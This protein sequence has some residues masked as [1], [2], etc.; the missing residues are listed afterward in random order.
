MLLAFLES[1]LEGRTPAAF[2]AVEAG[3]S[4]ISTI[5]ALRIAFVRLKG[6]KRVGIICATAAVV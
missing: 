2:I 1:P 6:R 3:L 5:A 4:R